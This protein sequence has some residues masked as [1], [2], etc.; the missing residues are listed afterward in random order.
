MVEFYCTPVLL[1]RIGIASKK[2][3]CYSQNEGVASLPLAGTHGTCISGVMFCPLFCQVTCTEDQVFVLLIK[4]RFV[5]LK[6]VRATFREMDQ[7][8]V[9]GIIG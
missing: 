5:T 4:Y 7:A 6:N 1:Q 8:A 3:P 2:I 9:F